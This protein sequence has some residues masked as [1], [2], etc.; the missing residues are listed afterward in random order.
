[1]FQLIYAILK[2]SEAPSQNLN[3]YKQIKNLC[4]LR[5]KIQKQ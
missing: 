4:E 2:L 5:G 1:M 3:N